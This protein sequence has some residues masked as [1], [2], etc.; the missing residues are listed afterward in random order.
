[1][2]AELEKLRE[3]WH[4][5]REVNI[6]HLLTTLGAIIVGGIFIAKQDV[7]IALIEQ[8]MFQQVS[9]DA[10]QDRERTEQKTELKDTLREIRDDIKALRTDVQQI[11]KR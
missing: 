8:S 4:V 3:P 9:V 2:S 7:R 11:A 6:T 5:K 10:R 1:M